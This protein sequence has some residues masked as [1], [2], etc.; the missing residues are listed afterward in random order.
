YMERSGGVTTKEQEIIVQKKTPAWKD[1]LCLEQ[2][3]DLESENWTTSRNAS[4][5]EPPIWT[6][7]TSIL[8]NGVDIL[9]HFGNTECFHSHKETL[10]RKSECTMAQLELESPDEQVTK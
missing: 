7:Q 4:T 8:D 10:R 3:P 1:L 6:L 9:K 2:I 5:K